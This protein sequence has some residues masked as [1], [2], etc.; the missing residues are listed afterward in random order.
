MT[1]VILSQPEK[2]E[3]CPKCGWHIIVKMAGNMWRCVHCGN[4]FEWEKSGEFIQQ[5]KEKG[6]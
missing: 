2:P 6:N 1:H 3:E 5:A 4:D